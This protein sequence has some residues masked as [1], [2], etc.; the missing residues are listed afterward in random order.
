VA[1][2]LFVKITDNYC[3]VI[4]NISFNIKNNYY[5]SNIM[6][7]IMNSSVYRKNYKALKIEYFFLR[8]ITAIITFWISCYHQIIIIIKIEAK[9]NSNS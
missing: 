2:Y 5:L 4:K 3:I 9:A 7:N 1:L 6:N 8:F